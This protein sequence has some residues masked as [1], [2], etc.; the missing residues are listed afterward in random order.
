[1]FSTIPLGENNNILVN[2][3]CGSRSVL[4]YIKERVDFY[5][6]DEAARLDL[7]DE[8]GQLKFISYQHAMRPVC[9]LVQP[10]AVL[11]PVKI[12]RDMETFCYKPFTP[13]VGD[14]ELKPKFQARLNLQRDSMERRRLEMEK[15][16]LEE[17]KQCQLETLKEKKEA[18]ESKPDK[19][20]SQRDRS[21][22]GGN[23][24]LKCT[25]SASRP[26]SNK[27]YKRP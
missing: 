27:N 21:N 20:E 18:M 19:Q 14:M 7:A 12:E 8:D 9:D 16:R 3:Q 17:E 6:P 15:I 2:T 5:S 23:Q 24:N 22:L 13:L 10:R 11:I 1:M 4:D 26:I 25:G